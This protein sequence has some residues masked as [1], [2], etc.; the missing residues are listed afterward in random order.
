[1]KE[2]DLH[3]KRTPRTT[4]EKMFLGGIAV[5]LGVIASAVLINSLQKEGITHLT[6]EQTQTIADILLWWFHITLSDAVL[7]LGGVVK[8]VYFEEGNFIKRKKNTLETSNRPRPQKFI[9][10]NHGNT[11]IQILNL[12]PGLVPHIENR[13]LLKLLSRPRTL[14]ALLAFAVKTSPELG[15]FGENQDLSR[16]DSSDLL[17]KT[18]QTIIDINFSFAK[19]ELSGK[20]VEISPPEEPETKSQNP[21]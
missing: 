1:M 3:H 13:L 12:P 17:F 7:K 20:V 19:G 15:R 8:M 9:R 10:V 21:T 5:D 6:P 2:R 4:G 11:D 18:A 14:K 16:Q